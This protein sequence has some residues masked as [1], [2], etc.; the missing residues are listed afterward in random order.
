MIYRPLTEEDFPG[1][2]AI[3]LEALNAETP[4]DTLPE[5]ERKA[6][7][8]ATLA[9]LRFYA[10]S[11]HSLVAVEAQ[12]KKADAVLGYVLAQAVWHGDRPT[13]QV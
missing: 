8:Q 5:Q 1:V 4:L 13:V 2:Q 10:R 12:A 9:A 7:V 11:G 3:E 6:R